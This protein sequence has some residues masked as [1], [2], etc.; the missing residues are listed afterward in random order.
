MSPVLLIAEH[1]QGFLN[2]DTL[3]LLNAG[4]ELA[5]ILETEAHVVI[6]GKNLDALAQDINIDGI[7]K[8]HLISAP[9]EY[10]HDVYIPA[11]S[12][13]FNKLKPS[14]ILSLH[15]S[16]GSDYSPAI[17]SILDIP[18]LPDVIEINYTNQIEI[19]H[20]MYSSKIQAKIAS[21][22]PAVITIRPGAW[23]TTTSPGNATLENF[24]VDIS[25]GLLNFKVKDYEKTPI[26]DV[27]IS[28]SDLLLSV[29]RGIEEEANLELIFSTAEIIGAA[30]SS[31]RPIVD[32]GWLPKDRQVGQSGTK[33][34]PSIYLAV[35]ISGSV[36]HIA[37]IKNSKVIISINKDP[38]A[39][40]FDVSDYGVVGDLFEILPALI[41]EFR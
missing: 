14:L 28:T 22:M 4:I 7:H 2:P 41:E 36:Q 31:S 5:T 30:V 27:D 17:A 26:G 34:S 25:E 8:I 16:T 37:G 13:L 11:I 1:R 10:T 12:S 38:K 18:F 3:G 33:I 15:T 40:I 9:S 35:G 20:E 24:D 19:I 39:P 32:A 29:G 6:I 23:P 21:Q